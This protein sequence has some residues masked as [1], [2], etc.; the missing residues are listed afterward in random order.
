[1]SIGSIPKAGT[2]R[3]L[4]IS[5]EGRYQMTKLV[6]DAVYTLRH[7]KTDED[8]TLPRKCCRRIIK[9]YGERIRY[10]N[11]SRDKGH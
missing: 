5:Y 10:T 3:K 2:S 11:Q 1:M 4:K 7:V 8:T 9:M 6:P